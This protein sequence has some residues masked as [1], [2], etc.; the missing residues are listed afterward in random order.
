MSD[1]H[2]VSEIVQKRMCACCD[3]DKIGD[4]AVVDGKIFCWLCFYLMTGILI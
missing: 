1:V 4:Y 3:A 2:D